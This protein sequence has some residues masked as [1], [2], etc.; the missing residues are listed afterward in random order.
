MQPTGLNEAELS[1]LDM[2]PPQERIDSFWIRQTEEIIASSVRKIQD[3]VSRTQE[4]I[5]RGDYIILKSIQSIQC[6]NPLSFVVG[7]GAC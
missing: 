7:P 1:L 5:D 6:Q 4:R 3:Q 2:N